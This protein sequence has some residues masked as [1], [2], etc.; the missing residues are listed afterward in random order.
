MPSPSRSRL[1][2]SLKG[3]GSYVTAITKTKIIKSTGNIKD[4]TY[5]FCTRNK[6]DTCTQRKVVKAEDLEQQFKDIITSITLRPD[7]KERALKE[8]NK[9]NDK[10]LHTRG[11]IYEL[12]L[13]ALMQTQRELDNLTKMHY[14][15]M[16]TEDEY[17]RQ[18]NE[19]VSKIRQLKER[20]KETEQ[21]ASTWLKTTERLFTFATHAY[22]CFTDGNISTKRDILRGLGQNYVL[23]NGKL[24]L[25]LF[26][27]LIPLQEIVLQR[28]KDIERFRTD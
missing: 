11:N 14:K 10:E 8:L 5:Y 18:R 22:D 24:N 23:Y 12:Q 21:R 17:L 25:Q 4:F 19:L 13:E 7:F 20:I 27:Y 9:Y 1:W 2:G 15:E 28:K 6:K 16:I 3:P 26:P